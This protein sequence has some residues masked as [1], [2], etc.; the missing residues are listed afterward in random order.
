LSVTIRGASDDLIIVEG[1]GLDEE[2][3]CDCESE[4]VLGVSDGTLIRGRYDAEGI[5]RFA[6]TKSGNCN[7]RVS[8]CESD[9]EGDDYTDIVTLQGVFYWICFGKVVTNVTAP[10]MNNDALQN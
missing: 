2:F 3:S 7:S 1:D 10:V 6:I 4:F 5:W 9:G 8:Q